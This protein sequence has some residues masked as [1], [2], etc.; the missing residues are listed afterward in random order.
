MEREQ[1]I[2]DIKYIKDV[3]TSS[4]NYT[5]LSGIAA[6]IS[7]ASALL[8]SIIHYLIQKEETHEILDILP[9]KP[10]IVWIVVFII[11]LISHLY[12]VFQKAK[13]YDIPVWSR[14]SKLSAYALSPSFVVG[15]FLTLFLALENKNAWIPS[16]WMIT[17]GL[18][19]WSAGLFSRFE[20]RYLGGS[21]VCIG[22]FTIFFAQKWNLIMLGISFGCFHIIY[23]LILLKK[24]GE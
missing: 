22:L 8:G 18:G 17:Y 16:I 2:D 5:N 1:L 23:G 21:F 20:P 4:I 14:L 3:I 15:A 12:F 13:K 19:V 24:Y 6:I 7:G 9:L 10:T 11:S